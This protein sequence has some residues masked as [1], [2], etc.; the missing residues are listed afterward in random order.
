[1]MP[2]SRPSSACWSRSSGVSGLDAGAWGQHAADLAAGHWDG[3]A[4]RLGLITEG[5]YG[6]VQALSA[7]GPSRH[8]RAIAGSPPDA[9][10]SQNLVVDSVTGRVVPACSGMR[11]VGAAQTIITKA[12]ASI[13][14]PVAPVSHVDFERDLLTTAVIFG[15]PY[16]RW[17]PVRFSR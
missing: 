16:P 15:T 1:M 4:G 12:A 9:E 2:T 5:A 14:R 8:A 10:R 13:S 11:A 17:N 7:D 3:P 6:C